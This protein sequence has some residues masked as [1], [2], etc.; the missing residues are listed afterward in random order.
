[1]KNPE[2]RRRLFLEK[3]FMNFFCEMDETGVYRRQEPRCDKGTE[4]D[5]GKRDFSGWTFFQ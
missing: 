2:F 1:M 5:G 3:H 4:K